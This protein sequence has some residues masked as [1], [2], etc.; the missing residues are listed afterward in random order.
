MRKVLIFFLLT[1]LYAYGEKL[2]IV[3]DYPLPYNNIQ[4]IYNKTKDINLIIELLKKTDD[5]LKIYAKDNTLY[6][7]RKLY[8]KDVKIHGNKS[9]WRREILAITGIVEGYSIDFNILH[10]IY[11]RLKKFYMDNGFPF[12][13]ITVKANIDKTGNIYIILDIYEGGEKEINDFLIYTSFPVSEQFKKEMINTLG[14][15]K[16]DIFNL[17]AITIGLDKLQNFLY[18]KDYY[19]SFVNLVSFKPANKS[20]VDVILFVD[21]GMKYNI[22][23]TG[24]RFFSQQQLKKVLTFAKNGFNYY[25]IVQSTENI[26]NLYK[27]NGFLEVT[28]IPSYK[29]YFKENKTE[30]FFLIHEGE[31]YKISNINIQTDIP[32]INN[33]LK[34]F[35]GKFYKKEKILNFLKQLREKYY[36]EGY[37]NA[38]YSLEEKIN[39]TNKT[40][41]LYLTFHKGKKFVIKDIQ[42]KNFSYKPD[43]K[44]PIPYDPNKILALLDKTKSRLKDEGYFDGDAFLDVKIKPADGIIETVV[45]IDVKKGERYKQGI[46]FIYGTRHLSPKMIINNLSKDKYYSKKEFDNELDF[47]YYTSLFD[48]INPYLKI[49]KKRKEVEKAYIL[50]EDKRGSFQGSFGYNTEQ[51]LKLSAAINLKN[52]FK[53]GFE[54][55]SYIEKNDLGWYYR[56]TF[57]NRL[58]PKRTGLFLSY[59]RNYEYHRIFDLETQGFELK[60]QRKP[61][62]WVEQT[63]SLQY[64][65]NSLKNQNIYPDNFFQTLK[66]RLSFIDNHREPRVNPRHGYIITGALTKEFQDINYFKLYTTGRYY[67]SYAFLTWTQK[68]SFGHIFKKNEQLP[69]SER[70]FLG[71]VSSFRGF[72]YENVAGKKGQGGNTLLLINN[73]IRYPLFPSVNLFGFVFMDIGNVYEKFNQIG[74]TLRKTAGTGAYIPTPVGSFL[75]DIAFKLDRQPGEDLYRLEFS[76]NTL[77]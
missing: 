36:R 74:G 38:N 25:Q 50:H 46:T 57:G 8:V 52:L 35:H 41:S 34:K 5:F 63:I 47:M 30:I 28:V 40:V 77:F 64:M 15:K 68:L 75:I 16:G 4:E 62:K 53:Y 45:I 19:D 39:K 33:F 31:R 72:G 26:E 9:F 44:L 65:R 20:K 69:P 14:V 42:I 70:F 61:N 24:N 58:L 67:L 32:E 22:H 43:I 71:G 2:K 66:L 76:I 21:L 23:F 27:K 51:K 37:L 49:D 18:E 7:K 48:A 3:S 6:L 60:V 17:S 10:N 11:T 55:S 54:T 13:Q 59:I 29:E 1:F 73:E 56:F 12:A